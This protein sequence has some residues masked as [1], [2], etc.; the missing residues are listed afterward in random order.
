MTGRETVKGREGPKGRY[1]HMGRDE[2][3]I[4]ISKRE[5]ERETGDR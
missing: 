2:I 5:R 3:C 4:E 1:V